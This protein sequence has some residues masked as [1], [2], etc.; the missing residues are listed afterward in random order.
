MTRRFRPLN[1]AFAT[2]PKTPINPRMMDGLAKPP[3]PAP[4]RTYFRSASFQ[5]APVL[6][7]WLALIGIVIPSEVQFFVAGAK[8]TPGRLG[9]I[10]LLLP[11][12]LKMCQNRRLLLSDFFAF[13]TVA[14]MVGSD[15]GR[16]RI[17][18]FSSTGAESLEFLGGYIVARG[19]FF[20]PIAVRTFVKI[21]TALAIISVLFAVADVNS[22]SYVVHKAYDALVHA[23][24]PGPTFRGQFIRAAAAFD[25]AIAF[26]VFCSLVTAVLLYSDVPRRL[27]YVGVCIFGCILSQ[28]SA[29]VISVFI[30]VSS[31]TYDRV[32]KKFP[33]RWAV[34]WLVV[35]SLVGTV[36]VVANHPLDWAINHLTL[37]PSTGWWRKLIWDAAFAK[38]PESPL[39]GFGFARLNDE[40]L[41]N[42]ID[43]AWLVY[44]LRFGLPMITFLLLTNLAA[45][46][47]PG[48]PSGNRNDDFMIGMQSAFT[49]VLLMFMFT[50]LTVHF[51][52]FMWIFWGL[53]IGIRASIREYSFVSIDRHRSGR[54]DST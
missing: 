15:F 18:S 41:D 52:N 45:L 50:A 32:M 53:C 17:E 9:I 7:A 4:A 54:L 47:P 26:G 31:Y 38:I 8:I 48:I 49:M 51:W 30:I 23:I 20:G 24:P 14:W 40:I 12:L 19:I 34:F 1:S 43:T 35:A 27:L 37:D 6:A 44:A 22:G 33:G 16:N 36:W 39:F 11:A 10:L 21:L 2:Q 28:S 46:L 13:A 3:R 42:T 5:R 29:A 25:H